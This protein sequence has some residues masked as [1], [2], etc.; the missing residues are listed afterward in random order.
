MTTDTL[1]LAASVST[2]PGSEVFE[3]GC[4]SGAALISAAEHNPGCAWTGLDIQEDLLA[5]AR[6]A[7]VEAGGTGRF[8]W[9]LC[10]VEN[11]PSTFS[12]GV[13]D[14]VIANPPYMIQ[15]SIRPSPSIVR[16]KARSA[17][18]LLLQRFIRAAA[19]LLRE[20]GSLVMV[21]RPDNLTTMLLGFLASGIAP[22]LLQ[23][24]GDIDRPAELV[25]LSGTKG[26]GSRLSILPQREVHW[27]LRERGPT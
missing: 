24:V 20:E 22:V 9:V 10:P 25:L 11:V 14:A 27:I 1:L 8:R 26:S 6:K 21:N 23:P 4:G 12:R 18:P 17:P 2:P 15:A 13:A 7:S 16:R 3:L 5:E 19:H